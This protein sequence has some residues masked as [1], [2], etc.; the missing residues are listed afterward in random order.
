MWNFRSH[1]PTSFSLQALFLSFFFTYIILSPSHWINPMSKLSSL[2][3]FLLFFKMRIISSIIKTNLNR[4]PLGP[5]A[6]FSLLISALGT[7]FKYIKDKRLWLHRKDM[8]PGK[9]NDNFC[10]PIWLAQS[11]NAILLL[12]FLFLSSIMH[13]LCI[14]I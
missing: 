2:Y 3:P 8:I 7:H 9:S 13:C 11:T 4:F 14:K 12:F 1:A 6:Q 10:R 5:I